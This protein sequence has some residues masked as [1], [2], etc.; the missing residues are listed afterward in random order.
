MFCVA[1]SFYQMPVNHVYFFLRNLLYLIYIEGYL[2]VP[3]YLFNKFRFAKINVSSL[4]C[5]VFFYRHQ[6]K[7][8]LFSERSGEK[9]LYLR[10]SDC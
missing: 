3:L 8:S 7:N 1:T 2:E 6:V 4:M 9:T 5:T 10:M